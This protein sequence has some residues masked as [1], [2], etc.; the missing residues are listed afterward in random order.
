[1]LRTRAHVAG[2]E[3]WRRR[4]A[5]RTEALVANWSRQL[6]GKIVMRFDRYVRR[7]IKISPHCPSQKSR[8]FQQNSIPIINKDSCTKQ[9]F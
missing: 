4:L 6:I 9:V 1:M 5:N 2:G 3:R 7:F 8:C